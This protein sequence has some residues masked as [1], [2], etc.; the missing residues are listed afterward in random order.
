MIKWIILGFVIFLMAKTG[1]IGKV[2]GFLFRNLLYPIIFGVIG[3]FIAGIL[4]VVIGAIAGFILS[5]VVT[6]KKNNL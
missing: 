2:F 3:F 6:K 4:G 5:F 1:S